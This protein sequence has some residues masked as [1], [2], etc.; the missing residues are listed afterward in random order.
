VADADEQRNRMTRDVADA[1][2]QR[3]AV[4]AMS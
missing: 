1:D 2:D 4:D 3:L